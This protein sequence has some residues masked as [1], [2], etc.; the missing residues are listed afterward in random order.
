MNLDKEHACVVI[1]WMMFTNS[2]NRS[3]HYSFQPI[4]LIDDL[5]DKMRPL[6]VRVSVEFMIPAAVLGR[7]SLFVMKTSITNEMGKM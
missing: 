5:T 4:P 6:E 2:S 7:E 3:R 1:A